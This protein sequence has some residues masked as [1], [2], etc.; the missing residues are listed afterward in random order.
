VLSRYVTFDE[1]S[2][3]KSIISQQVERM[4]TKDVSQR[5]EVNATP[6]FSVGA[7]SVGISP[8]LTPRGDHVAIL[9]AE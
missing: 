1:V 7:V 5:M 4:K 2:L 6:L 3:L 8:D 9:D